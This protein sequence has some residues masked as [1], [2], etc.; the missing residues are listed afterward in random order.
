MINRVFIKELL[1]FKN[2]D[3]EF[4]NGLIAITGPSGAGKS[5]FISSLLAN[6]GLG[7]QEAK[8]CEVEI[9]RPK[10]LESFKRVV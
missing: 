6:F 8:L 2:I 10:G 1:S 3:L 9:D 4:K 7:N 5:V